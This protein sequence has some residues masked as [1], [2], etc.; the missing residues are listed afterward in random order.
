MIMKGRYFTFLVI[1]LLGASTPAFAQT[2]VIFKDARSIEV[3]SARYENNQCIYKKNGSERSVPLALIEEIY[4]LNQGR[5][6]P[7]Q[8]S[9]P[10]EV[11][12][13]LK[14]SI[15]LSGPESQRGAQEFAAADSKQTSDIGISFL[16]PSYL[17]SGLEKV[18]IDNE[19]ENGRFTLIY[20]CEKDGKQSLSLRIKE[21][22]LRDKSYNYPVGPLWRS[23]KKYGYAQEE[24]SIGNQTAYFYYFDENIKSKNS[25]FN[26]HVRFSRGLF[27]TTE[28]LYIEI[29]NDRRAA[30]LYPKEE[31]IKIAKS[32]SAEVFED[33]SAR[34]REPISEPTNECSFPGDTWNDEVGACLW[35]EVTDD[36]QIRAAKIAVEYI[37]RTEG[38]RVIAVAAGKCDGCYVV[39]IMKKDGF[40]HKILENWKVIEYKKSGCEN[41]ELSKD[42][43][44]AD[45]TRFKTACYLRAGDKESVLRMF[46][47]FSEKSLIL[48]MLDQEYLNNLAEWL[49]K[50]RLHRDEGSM[51]WYRYYETEER[52]MAFAIYKPQKFWGLDSWLIMSF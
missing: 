36:N 46:D 24:V 50:A 14:T 51:R 31:L 27:W 6:Y 35:R 40:V 28:K 22:E 30:C 38:L 19:I 13:R 41:L 23:S 10:A 8:Q 1:T 48:A 2:L 42:L 34:E 11:G 45:I 33:D 25:A 21:R 12:P 39:K 18:H 16:R 52:F 37:G 20:R 15:E 49:E 4:V 29:K 5:I 43:H 7:P 3:D 44:E 9:E 47:P 26:N 17:P 32:M